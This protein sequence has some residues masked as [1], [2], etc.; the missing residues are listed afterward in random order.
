MKNA[1]KGF[2]LI[3]VM[4]VVAIVAILAAIAY[5]NYDEY[6]KRANRADG[7]ALLNDIAARQERY[8]AQNNAYITSINDVGKLYGTAETSKSSPAG[9]YTL[10]VAGGGG[11][12][13]LTAEQ[14]FGD[15]AC[16]DLTLNAQGLRGRSGSEKTIEECWR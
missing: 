7:Q 6:R 10:R 2:T 8:Y 12:Y 14:K 5:P 9:K 15:S 11:G 1:N 3:E 13:T 16:G 4:I